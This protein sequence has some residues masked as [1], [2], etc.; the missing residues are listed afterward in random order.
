MPGHKL[1]PKRESPCFSEPLCPH[2]EM[3]LLIAALSALEGLGGFPALPVEAEALQR[4][5]EVTKQTLWDGAG[6]P[7]TVD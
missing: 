3:G 5:V 1:R 4:L 2:S 6:F 7:D